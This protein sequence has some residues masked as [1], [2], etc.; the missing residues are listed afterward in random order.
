M[1]YSIVSG[2]YFSDNDCYE[3][4]EITAPWHPKVS[5]LYGF[6]NNGLAAGYLKTSGWP[7]SGGNT[8]HLGIKQ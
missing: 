6:Q 4:L 8:W 1:T 2:K 3:W 7:N 5:D